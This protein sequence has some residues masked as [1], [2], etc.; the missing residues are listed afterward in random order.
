MLIFIDFV[1]VLFISSEAT[2]RHRVSS[3][4]INGPAT[5]AIDSTSVDYCW[6][7]GHGTAVWRVPDLSSNCRS[8]WS[9]ALYNN[10]SNWM[11]SDC[12]AVG[13]VH[14]HCSDCTTFRSVT[15][16]DNTYCGFN[17]SATV[18]V[19]ASS[20]WRIMEI[21]LCCIS[22]QISE[23]IYSISKFQPSCY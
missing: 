11:F 5:R 16:Q 18:Y 17:E 12:T 10:T 21:T 14:N 7:S 4:G 20:Y 19:N 15:D 23:S 8:D 1:W 6:W 2:Q 22:I 9:I 13:A 3:L